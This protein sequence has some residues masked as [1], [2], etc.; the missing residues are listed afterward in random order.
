VRR[1]AGALRGWWTDRGQVTSPPGR[2][3]RGAHPDRPQRPS[4]TAVSR[5]RRRVAMRSRS[6]PRKESPCFEVRSRPPTPSLWG[7][8][9]LHR[10]STC[11][12]RIPRP[13][14]S[15]PHR[16]PVDPRR[17]RPPA[18]R[19]SDP[20]TAG[21]AA[22][23]PSNGPWHRLTGTLW[24]GLG[25]TVAVENAFDWVYA[26]APRSR[27]DLVSSRFGSKRQ[28]VGLFGLR[29][30]CKLGQQRLTAAGSGY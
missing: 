12:C 19:R 29:T 30:A 15:R 6:H 25:V 9:H 27:F 21:F 16:I 23:R 3:A 1:D 24:A 8:I 22:R 5:A 7:Q 4:T 17:R 13:I 10:E 18:T 20:N 28:H 26:I 14:R 2:G 11:R